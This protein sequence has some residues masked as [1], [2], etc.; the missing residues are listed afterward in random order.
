M[1]KKYDPDVVRPRFH[2]RGNSARNPLPSKLDRSFAVSTVL[3]EPV[4]VFV[5][6]C[7]TY[8]TYVRTYLRA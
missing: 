8:L 5:R 3:N 6:V 1:I 4:Y 2:P 7:L